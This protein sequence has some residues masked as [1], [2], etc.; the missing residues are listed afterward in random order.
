[1]THQ[2]S[3][4]THLDDIIL[5]D[6]MKNSALWFPPYFRVKNYRETSLNIM[7][8]CAVDNLKD[9]TFIGLQEDM[10]GS[11][12][13]FKESFPKIKV[14]KDPNKHKSTSSKF[15]NTTENDLEVLEEMNKWDIKLYA[16]AK[17]MT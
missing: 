5:S 4:Q 6:E 17:D 12:K 9:Y 14:T 2:L 10:E 13:R 1:M 15:F 11:M 3:G 8:N 7:L 16:A